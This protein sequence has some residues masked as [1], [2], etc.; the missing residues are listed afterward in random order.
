MRTA[1]SLPYGGS[2]SRGVSVRGSLSEGSLSRGISVWGVSVWGSLSRGSLSGGLC[3]GGF[4]SGGLC[5]GGSLSR[6][7][8]LG[9]G[10]LSRG[11][12][13]IAIVSLT[14]TPS[15]LWTE[16]LT[17]R[18]KNITLPQRVVIMPEVSTVAVK[19]RGTKAS[20]RRMTIV[21]SSTFNWKQTCVLF[22]ISQTR[23]HKLNG[24]P[25]TLSVGMLVS[26]FRQ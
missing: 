4:L 11:L 2:V 18:C 20:Q 21:S 8:C 7:L 17:D 16:W 23:T 10:S 6:E 14:E 1:R 3:P 9:G 22:R 24:Y 12:S 15:S 13:S 5:L 19:G 25:D 26:R